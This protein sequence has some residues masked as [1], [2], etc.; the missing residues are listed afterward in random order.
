MALLPFRDRRN[1]VGVILFY[2]EHQSGENGTTP[3]A[4]KKKKRKVRKEEKVFAPWLRLIRLIFH[5][6]PIRHG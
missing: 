3:Q 4:K 5:S 1:D 6:L 2:L